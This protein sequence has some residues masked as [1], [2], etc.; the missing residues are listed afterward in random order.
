MSFAKAFSKAGVFRVKI[1]NG[2]IYRINDSA[3]AFPAED[4]NKTRANHPFRTVVV[5]SNQE[6]CNDANE[7][8]VLVAPMSG[9][10]QLKHP[11][12]IEF[13]PDGENG[14]NK[15]GRILLGHIQPI[16]KTDLQKQ[17]GCFPVRTGS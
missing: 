17:F 13:D 2:G 7:E 6:H 1:Q 5:L 8:E 10:L 16:L 9:D 11:T 15:P 14:L 3:I 4:A 12:D